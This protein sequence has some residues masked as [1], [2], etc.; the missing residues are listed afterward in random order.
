MHHRRRSP[1]LPEVAA[2][3]LSPVPTTPSPGLSRAV[4]IHTFLFSFSS[5]VFSLLF[6]SALVLISSFV[7]ELVPS[8]C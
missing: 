7:S 8:E 2:V 4:Y 6:S 5:L 1:R 3:S